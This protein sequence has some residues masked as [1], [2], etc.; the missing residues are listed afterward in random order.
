MTKSLVVGSVNALLDVWEHAI[1]VDYS[2]AT[3]LPSIRSAIV[4]ARNGGAWNG[5]GITSSAAA[6]QSTHNTTL[7]LMEGSDYRSIYGSA[8]MFEGE[9]VDATAVLVKYTYYGDTDF[10]ELVNFDDYSRIDNGFNSGGTDWLHGDFDYNGVVNFDDYSLIDLAF[11][12]QNGT[13]ARA[14]SYL[15]G[16]DRNRADMK[17]PALAM[18]RDHFDRF[19]EVYAQGFLN[20]V[21]E[22]AMASVLIPALLLRRRSRLTNLR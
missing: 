6:I 13:L 14:T 12:S 16:G 22:P 18:V 21:P 3:P 19:G 8:A 10:N 11:N 5:F 1:L 20:S 2:G 15:D 17:L 4:S 7:G 9:P